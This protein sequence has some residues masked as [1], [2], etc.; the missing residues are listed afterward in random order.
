VRLHGIERVQEPTRSRQGVVVA[1]AHFGNPE[2]AVQVGALVGLDI[3]VLAEPLSPPSFDEMMTKLRGT[4]GVRYED[5]SFSAVANAIKHLR[6]GG[7]LA[8]ICDRDIQGTGTPLP[9][10]GEETPLPLGA[11]ELAARTG[12][13]LIPGYSRR[14]GSTFDITFE[15]PIE[16]EKT[17]D[18]DADALTNAR[19]LLKVAEGWIRSDPGQWMV[20]ER[21][22]KPQLPGFK[23]RSNGAGTGRIELKTTDIG[24]IPVPPAAE[25]PVEAVSP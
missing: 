7:V 8:I 20:L 9:F 4:F 12:S 25:P 16:M 2:M 1:T 17:G 21:I 5:V 23:S 14:M 13:V 24:P 15:A 3:L 19:K 18:R 10:F 22:W 6:K 11:V